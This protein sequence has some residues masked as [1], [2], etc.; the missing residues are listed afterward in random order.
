MSIERNRETVVAFY[1][2]VFND[3]DPQ[4]AA[5]AH[6]GERYVQHNPTAPDG[7]DGFLTFTAL[8]AKRA[9]GL[10]LEILRSVAEDDYVVTHSRLTFPGAP[11]RSVMDW[12]RLEHGKIVEHWDAVQQV[13]ATSANGNGMF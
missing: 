2:R 11:E 5:D 9:P 3:K 12:W 1:N 10:H 4:G 7:R 6:M 13:P 8:L